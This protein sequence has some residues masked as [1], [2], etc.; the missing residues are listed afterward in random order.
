MPPPL[1]YCFH[2][3][4]P[5]DFSTAPVPL[6]RRASLGQW[7]ALLLIRLPFPA[8]RSPNAAVPSC[9]GTAT[10]P[11]LPFPTPP[12]LSLPVGCSSSPRRGCPSRSSHRLR[13][14][15]RATACGRKRVSPG[16]RKAFMPP[17]LHYCFHR[18]APND[19]STAPVPLARRASLGQWPA[20][21]LIRL[22][23]PAARSPNAAVPSC[24]GTAT[25]PTLPFPTPP[26]LSLPVG[27]SSSPRRGC[28]SRSS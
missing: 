22:P 23:F 17:P 25:K 2:R 10:K 26:S 27:C 19:F 3:S 9:A 14:A 11:T 21:L 28:A 20:L 12:S 24:A 1:H 7:P 18:P 5:N 15:F 4:A 13:Q 8:A 6:A 16:I